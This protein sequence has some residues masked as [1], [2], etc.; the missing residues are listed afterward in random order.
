MSAGAQ[1]VNSPDAPGDLATFRCA[2]VCR[3]KRTGLWR[4]RP[5]PTSP[6]YPIRRRYLADLPDFAPTHQNNHPIPTGFPRTLD[7]G[8]IR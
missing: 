4:E 5:S 8:Y 6:I 3:C 2:C 7:A 1:Q